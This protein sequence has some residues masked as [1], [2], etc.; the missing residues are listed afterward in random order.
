MEPDP[1]QLMVRM[2]LGKNPRAINDT[3]VLL[4]IKY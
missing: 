1:L 2:A 4:K 3:N